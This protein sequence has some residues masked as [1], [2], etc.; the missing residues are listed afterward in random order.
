[1]MKRMILLRIRVNLRPL[2]ARH[3]HRSQHLVVSWGTQADPLVLVMLRSQGNR[4]LQ[5]A[6]PSGQCHRLEPPRQSLLAPSRAPGSHPARVLQNRQ[7]GKFILYSSLFGLSLMLATTDWV[8]Q[9]SRWTLCSSWN[10]GVAPSHHFVR[11]VGQGVHRV[12]S[13]L[14]STLHSLDPWRK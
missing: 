7:E 2:V 5:D 13:C 12:D 8:H 14:C 10:T 6:S 11:G 4:Q 3:Q 1:M 9:H